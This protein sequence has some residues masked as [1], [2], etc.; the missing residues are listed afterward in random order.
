MHAVTHNLGTEVD[1]IRTSITEYW[2]NSEISLYSE[3]YGVEPDMASFH[4][5]GYFSQIVWKSTAEV[6]CAVAFCSPKTGLARYPGYY[7]VC[8][9]T[10]LVTT[11]ASSQLMSCLLWATRL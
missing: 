5:W 4:D 8:N 3:T 2:Y 11:M 7:S 10:L 1:F 9:I 6:G